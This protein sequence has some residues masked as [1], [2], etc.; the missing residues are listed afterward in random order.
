MDSYVPFSFPEVYQGLASGGG[1]ATATTAGLTLEFQVKDG[2]VGII[3]SDIRKVVIPI[4]ELRSCST[5][6]SDAEA[7]SSARESFEIEGRL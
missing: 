7:G 3:K 4:S 5:S 1:I 2:F 6:Q